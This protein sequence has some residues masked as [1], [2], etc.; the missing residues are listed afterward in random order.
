MSKLKTPSEVSEIN[1]TP[2]VDVMLV[3]LIIM[4]VI[5]P[6]L[7][8][9][10]SVDLA[11]TKNPRDMP[12]AEKTDAVE[13]AITRDGKFFLGSDPIAMADISSKIKDRLSTSSEKIVF[14]KSDS[15]AKYGL[16]TDAVDAIR[17]AGIEN[18]GLETERIQGRQATLPPPN[19]K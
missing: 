16:V 3:L 4:M 10:I 15:R 19:L 1:V 6:M 14:V 12:A 7:Q 17:A 11:Q 2:M 13:L 8:H 9:N 5:T 18:I